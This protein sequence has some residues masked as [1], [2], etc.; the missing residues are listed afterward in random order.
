[1]KIHKTVLITGGT[2]GIGRAIADVFAKNGY[3]LILT[4]S[5]DSQAA[6]NSIQEI[7]NTCLVE[8]DA[9]KAD[10]IQ[11]DSIEKIYS[12]L[13]DRNI[14]LDVVVFNAAITLRSSFEETIFEDWDRVFYANI[15]FPVFLLQRILKRINRGGSVL[16]TGSLM[17][18]QPHG[19]SLSYGVTKSATHSLVKNLVKYLTPYD[20]RV[21][22]VAPGFI[23]TDWQLTKSAEIRSNIENKIALR[24]F[25]LPQE[26]SE[27]FLMLVDNQYFNGEIIKIDG[28]YSY[29]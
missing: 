4:Y 5:S 29:R 1:M 18:I 24:R 6:Q 23:D 17:G 25:G 27:V 21:N 28:G 9:I 15:H 2:K 13:H 14:F 11:S 26:I 3:N 16:F 10:S 8:V 19:T 22:G 7:K 20:I 12:Y